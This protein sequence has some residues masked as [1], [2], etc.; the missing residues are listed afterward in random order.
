M[1]VFVWTFG[2]IIEAGVLAL[3]VCTLV[4]FVAVMA[5]LDVADRVKRRKEKR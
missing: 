1:S 5:V 2:D 3:V 4:S